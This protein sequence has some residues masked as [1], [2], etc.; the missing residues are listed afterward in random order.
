MLKQLFLLTFLVI[1]NLSYSQDIQQYQFNLHR[2]NDSLRIESCIPLE[3]Y[4][5]RLEKPQLNVESK[6]AK[7]EIPMHVIGSKWD[8]NCLIIKWPE[9][10]NAEVIEYIKEFTILREDQI[11]IVEQ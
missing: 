5:Q 11:I 6:I 8:N 1:L 7:S 4:H 10:S 3:L 9:I 2:Y